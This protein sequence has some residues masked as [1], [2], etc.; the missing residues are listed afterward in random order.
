MGMHV[1]AELQHCR[2]QRLSCSFAAEKVA[3]SHK[4]K[5]RNESGSVLESGWRGGRGGVRGETR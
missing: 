5:H 2:D 4:R 1:E 3:E